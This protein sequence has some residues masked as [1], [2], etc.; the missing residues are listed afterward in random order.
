MSYAKWR[1]I[2]L[3]LKVLMIETLEVW[4]KTNMIIFQRTLVAAEPNEN[5]PQKRIESFTK[6][7][8]PIYKRN[9]IFQEA[10]CQRW[11]KS[12]P[13]GV[14]IASGQSIAT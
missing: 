7:S 1:P 12:F 6:R 13:C 4:D 10:C 11:W 2:S 5:G 8:V 3:S 9:V 14:N